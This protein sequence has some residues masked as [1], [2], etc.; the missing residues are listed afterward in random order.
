MPKTENL[1]Y[2]RYEPLKKMYSF[3]QHN[4]EFELYAALCNQ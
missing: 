1:A 2:F 4:A 3:H